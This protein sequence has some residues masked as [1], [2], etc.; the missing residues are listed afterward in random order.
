MLRLSIR[1]R[2]QRSAITPRIKLPIAEAASVRVLSRPAVGFD[3]PNWRMSVAST[4]EYSI[5]SKASSIQPSPAATS[6]LRCAGVVARQRSGTSVAAD[7]VARS[8]IRAAAAGGSAAASDHGGRG[9]GGLDRIHYRV[10]GQPMRAQ[11]AGRHQALKAGLRLRLAAI[12]NGTRIPQRQRGGDALERFRA[13]KR[14]ADEMRLSGH[15][16]LGHVGGIERP[17][18]MREG[19]RAWRRQETVEPG[20]ELRLR[21][22]T[23]HDLAF[24]ETGREKVGP[25]GLHGDVAVAVGEEVAARGGRDGAA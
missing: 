18:E 3:M 12:V 15:L 4:S 23:A 2:P 20:G 10:G 11:I 17:G 5:T 1:R 13:G 8:L 7:R 22:K 16:I 24:G 9:R 25:A 19:G 21:Q 6:V 14:Q